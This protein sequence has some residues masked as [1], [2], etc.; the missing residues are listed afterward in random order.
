MQSINQQVWN[1]IN[2]DAAIQKGLKRDVINIRGL[3]KFFIKK[4]NVK[5]SL[6]SVISAI[7]RYEGSE[8][9]EEIDN[10]T[11]VFENCIISTKNNVACITLH[12]A[13]FDKLTQI[14]DL[15]KSHK[16]S[17][18]RFISGTNTIKLVTDNVHKEKVLSIFDK[19]NIIH[20]EDDLSE[21]NVTLSKVAISK[22]GVLAKMTNEIALNNVNILELLIT[23]PDFLIYVREKDIVKTHETLLKLSE[24]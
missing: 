15:Q 24:S 6:D 17:K 22:H 14:F 13:S 21:V 4:H 5:A 23:P 9:F 18:T 2:S 1:I 11:S 8:D 7:R 10:I 3:A 16:I 12:V 20:V 19:K